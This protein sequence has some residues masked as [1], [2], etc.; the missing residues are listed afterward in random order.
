[1]KKVVI[2]VLLIAAISILAVAVTAV[3]RRFAYN[4]S[5]LPPPGIKKLHTTFDDATSA[6][7]DINARHML[8]Y[9]TALGVTRESELLRHDRDVDIAMFYEDIPDWDTL[10]WTMAV[11][12]FEC[13]VTSTPHSWECQG[14]R[15]PALFQYIHRG[16]GVGCDIVVLY[17][18]DCCIW[19]IAGGAG[20]ETARAIDSATQNRAASISEVTSIRFSQW[21]GWKNI[22]AK[23]GG[24][25]WRTVREDRPRSTKTAQHASFH[26]RVDI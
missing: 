17:R 22:M 8:A 14:Q 18:H 4:L 25:L 5:W 2:L 10:N 23:V 24:Y 26:H 16:T 11:Y 7:R 19:D 21:H 20:G 1:M 12:G 3:N 15:Y 13:P 9:G 6:L